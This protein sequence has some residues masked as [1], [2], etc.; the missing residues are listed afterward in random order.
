VL[1]PAGVL[2]CVTSLLLVAPVTAASGDPAARAAAATD[3]V[4]GVAGDIA[5]DIGATPT[6]N[7]C[8]QS[9]TADVLAGMG[10]DAVL[11]LG[12]EQYEAGSAASFAQVYDRSWGRFKSISH[13]VVGNHEYETPNASGYFGYFGAAAG[14]PSRGYYSWDI[15][16]WHLIALNSECAYTSQVG[17]AAGS[18]QEQWLRADLAANPGKCTLAYWH[19][20]RFTAGGSDRTFQPFWQDLYDA[21]ADVV[22]NGH[23][24]A[25]ERFAPQS[26]TGAADANGPREFVVGTGGADQQDLGASAPN[27]LV[28]QSSTF[29]AL[30]LTLHAGSYDWQF[31]PVAGQS[32]TDSGSGT[33]HNART[34]GPVPAPTPSPA[35]APAPTGPVTPGAGGEIGGS[36]ATYYLNTTFGPVADQVFRYGDPADR[37]VVGDWDGDGV[38]T[39]LIRRG[40]VFFVRNSNST[41]TADRSFTYGDPGDTVLV[42]D[43]DGDGTDTLAVRRGNTYHVRNSLSTGVADTVFTY[44][45]NRDTVLVGD[46]NGDRRA[47]LAVR[48]GAQYLVRNTLTTGVADATV[49]YGDPA[50]TVLVGHWSASQQGD[51]LAVRRGNTFYFRYSLS[52][53]TADRVVGY[54]DP[55]DTAFAGDWNGRGI[56]TLGIR[57][58]P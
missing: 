32:W 31:V 50:D 6:S 12:D 13:P 15:G 57:R 53:G 36:G 46:W 42:G 23:T 9:A 49:T 52:S 37:V 19:E 3:P 33:C 14:D 45:D 29:G 16:A 40:N 43:W 22:L 28:R 7:S 44:G 39:P 26:P 34:P 27:E 35:P 54:G 2:L 51:S 48:R 11:P 1:A 21:H 41:G 5:C 30:K 58:R 20:P 38:D 10:A 55:T 47:T 24:H 25:Y 56:D 18:A 8:Q 17:C 4:L